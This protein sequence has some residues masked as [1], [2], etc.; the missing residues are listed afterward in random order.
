MIQA[1]VE[2]RVVPAGQMVWVGTQAPP[3]RVE[4]VGQVPWAGTQAPLVKVMPAGH[5]D[6]IAETLQNPFWHTW[7]VAQTLPHA[8]QFL[9]SDPRFAQVPPQRFI[10]V[11]HP[12]GTPWAVI[13][14][15]LIRVV[16]VGQVV[17]AGTQAPPAN[18]VPA[19]QPPVWAGT[20]V[21]LTSVVPA[22]HGD[23]IAE[24]LQNPFWQ[25]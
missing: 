8:P 21:P 11:G 17:W 7:P 13:Q 25:T 9:A 18:V 19:G 3:V 5:G 16:P 6:C 15:P 24:T 2:L 14:T 10:P 23:C 12:V 1:P 22:G 20:Q 4:P